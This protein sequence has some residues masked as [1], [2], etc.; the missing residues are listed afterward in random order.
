MLS[1][2]TVA[3]PYATVEVTNHNKREVR[4]TAVVHFLDSTG[5]EL[6]VGRAEVDVPARGAEQTLVRVG[7]EG[8]DVGRCEAERTA[9]QAG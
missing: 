7:V 1:C 6:R 4:Y 5:A 3:K 9:R 2:A 8:L